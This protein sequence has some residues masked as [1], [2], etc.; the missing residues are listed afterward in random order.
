MPSYSL[1]LNSYENTIATWVIKFTSHHLS[2]LN[3][4]PSLLQLS[5]E[6]DL[7]PKA[8]IEIE[9]VCAE[10]KKG[11]NSFLGYMRIT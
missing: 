11:K 1:Q 2:S 10:L 3:S 6:I 9:M 8:F 7:S 5:S 4:H